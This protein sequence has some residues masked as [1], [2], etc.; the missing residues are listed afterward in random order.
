MKSS[1]PS[2][3]HCLRESIKPPRRFGSCA[4]SR[5]ASMKDLLLPNQSSRFALH[6]VAVT[7][8]S[9]SKKQ[10]ARCPATRGVLP[11]LVLLGEVSATSGGGGAS[12]SSKASTKK[13]TAVARLSDDQQQR[14]AIARAF[15]GQPKLFIAEKPSGAPTVPLVR[16]LSSSCNR[17]RPSSRPPCWS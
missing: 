11:A 4:S 7:K 10:C 6:T 13:S 17:Q 15:A 2:P 9:N 16:R 1:S 5:S 14:E 8:T 3:T 12:V